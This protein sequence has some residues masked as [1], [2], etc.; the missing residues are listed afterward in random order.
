MNHAPVVEL[1]HQGGRATGAVV[2]DSESGARIEVRARAVV[3]AAGVWADDVRA[4]DEGQHPHAIRPAK[5]IH[6]TVP[7]SLVRNDVAVVAPVPKDKRS[8]FVVPW[9]APDGQDPE[10]TYIGTT[11]TDYDGPTEDP[12]CTREDVEYLLGAI[13]HS[14]TTEIAERHVV[15]TWAGLR[16]L[17]KATTSGRTADL[18]RNHAVVTSASGVVSVTGGKLT[19]YREMATDA[20]GAVAK[21]LELP[22]SQRR[23]QTSKLALLGAEGYDADATG[24]A[25]HLHQR[26]GGEARVVQAMAERDPSLAE[27]LVAGL[28]HLRAEAVYAVR[29]EMATTLADVLERRVRGL[30]LSRDATADAA[31][32]VADLIGPELGWSE[33]RRADEVADLRARAVQQRDA[34]GLP[35]SVLPVLGS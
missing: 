30:M 19:T 16:P 5:G 27:P 6:L 11:D 26:Y 20:M 31:A 7:W 3:N 33:R 8:V 14:T 1:V 9:P 17:V 18:S 28:P 29:Y 23:S 24:V 35:A 13:N 21:V 22:R 4:L 2:E 15:G 34:P 25:Q 32:A 10:F 12:Q